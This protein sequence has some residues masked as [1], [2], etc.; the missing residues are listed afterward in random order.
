M[1][2]LLLASATVI[3]C[4]RRAEGGSVAPGDGRAELSEALGPDLGS[5]AFRL[6]GPLDRPPCVFLR[7]ND[8]PALDPADAGAMTPCVPL[9][10]S[11]PHF[12][13]FSAASGRA[14]A[15]VDADP[16]AE[17]LN[18]WA[19]SKLLAGRK[20]ESAFQWAGEA[21]DLA[22]DDP[23]LRNDL[24]VARALLALQSGSP[25]DLAAAYEDFEKAWT[26]ATAGALDL[27][28][29]PGDGD[30][31]DEDS[32]DET[33]AEV[34]LANRQLVLAYLGASDL[35]VGSTAGVTPGGAL[36]GASERPRR[37]SRALGRPAPP[38]VLRSRF[39]TLLTAWV[40][41]LAN[42]DRDRAREIRD[43][44]AHTAAALRRA[45]DP[46]AADV[47][48][49]FDRTLATGEDGERRAV[50]SWQRWQEGVQLV[51]GERYPEA[52]R[53]LAA[54]DRPLERAFGPLVFQARRA[55]F[56]AHYGRNHYDGALD[57][58]GPGI[59]S[60][61][62]RYPYVHGDTLRL[63]GLVAAIRGDHGSALAYYEAAVEPTARSGDPA[64]DAANQRTIADTLMLLEDADGAWYHLRLGLA[65]L[66]RVD[67]GPAHYVFY[68]AAQA[69][70]Q[71]S[72]DLA[73]AR[74]FAD[75]AVPLAEGFGNPVLLAGALRLRSE[76]L[77]AL[78]L[79]DEA[80]ADLRAA[81]RLLPSLQDKDERL[82]VGADLDLAEAKAL[83]TT[84]PTRALEIVDRAV[85]ALAHTD[86]A[87]KLPQAL[88][89][90]GRSYRTLKEWDKA[91]AAIL[92]ALAEVNA[93]LASLDAL[94]PLPLSH[95]RQAA[96]FELIRAR[97]DS[98][99]GED[100]GL[101]AVDASLSLPFGQRL[102]RSAGLPETSATAAELAAGLPPNTHALV[103]WIDDEEL[104]IW[105]VLPQ[106][107]VL[108][109]IQVSR[110]EIEEQVTA[111]LDAI[112][113]DH[114]A[115]AFVG[116][117]EALYDL[118]IAPV[119]DLLAPGESLLIAAAAPL[120]ALPFGVLKEPDSGRIVLEDH[121]LSFAPSL[122]FVRQLRQRDAL[123]ARRGSEPDSIQPHFSFAAHE[124]RVAAI[125]A[126]APDPGRHGHQ[127]LLPRAAEEAENVVGLLDASS[128]SGSLIGP[129]AT[130]DALLEASHD[131]DI[132]Y[133]TGHAEA[134]IGSDP[135]LLLAGPA[136][137]YPD[138]LLAMA[139]TGPGAPRL[140]RPR[141]VILS[142]CATAA[143]STQKD[144]PTAFLTAGA[145]TVV[146][147]LWP[148]YDRPTIELMESFLR[149]L[150][151]G[152]S[153]PEALRK[154]QLEARDAGEPVRDWGA[155]RVVGGVLSDS[156]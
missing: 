88:L 130:R 35:A 138:D 3:S 89:L 61:T 36:E 76:T 116:P 123:A 73:L 127:S 90:K 113:N 85:Q 12:K 92:S 40:G 135:H 68:Q 70:A 78:G 120:Q 62:A 101:E 151:Q 6:S 100:R 67:S 47:V 8:S 18:A 82:S 66:R 87:I 43:R 24:G 7:E 108:R 95:Q 44:T 143:T 51:K 150:T 145:S 103:Y 80:L 106:A 16:S 59:A 107:T 98:G 29:S 20:L 15:R 46:W 156:W 38:P 26:L 109:R 110:R 112:A 137:L 105:S 74:V 146:A 125:A 72:G 9:A 49:A 122:G 32:A 94:D 27:G 22:P 71:G 141:L 126:T 54:V 34:A 128:S 83:A 147:N 58:L 140:F 17:H 30:S 4:A 25:R 111:L 10:P 63:A 129:T 118:L 104:C 86:Y 81:R 19:A 153:E 119:A 50:S 121:A 13:D 65:S 39:D 21:A 31:A 79:T 48:V 53:V 84:N 114:N 144:L 64:L 152:F 11:D 131:A 133:Y 55:R 149:Y 115:D 155:G 96:Y 33:T 136:D 77:A 93:Q 69:V 41:A 28:E 148:V 134:P 2:C 132:L 1:I 139:P 23:E 14:N 45:G 91:E 97:L 42:G 99:C 117:S 142:A 56:L 60:E 37:G 75:T 52:A 57:A 102:A 124:L 5:L 154:A